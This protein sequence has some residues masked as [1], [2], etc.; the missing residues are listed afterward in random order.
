MLYL[1]CYNSCQASSSGMRS[2]VPLRSR[3]SCHAGPHEPAQ[4]PVMWVPSTEGAQGDPG[5][6]YHVKA[7]LKELPRLSMYR[8]E[9]RGVCDGRR[10]STH[11]TT[12][13]RACCLAH[14]LGRARP[15]APSW[16]CCACSEPTRARRSSTSRPSRS[17]LFDTLLCRPPP[18]MMLSN[19]PAAVFDW[20]SAHGVCSS[21]DEQTARAAPALVCPLL[22]AVLPRLWQKLGAGTVHAYN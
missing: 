13:M 17:H 11:F 10:L 15:S 6:C 4:M 3:S 18:D 21:C 12:R 1:A 22:V 16:P 7:R 14:P 20:S 9:L 8:A 19:F 2:L 5:T